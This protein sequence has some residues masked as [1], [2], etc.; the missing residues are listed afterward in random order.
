MVTQEKDGKI[1]TIT[2]EI[3]FLEEAN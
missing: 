2:P 1:K 3:D